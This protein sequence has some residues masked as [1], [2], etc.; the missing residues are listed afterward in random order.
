MKKLVTLLL[1]LALLATI[2]PTLAEGDAWV[3]PSCGTEN[4]ADNRFCGHCGTEKNDSWVC[5]S[6]GTNNSDNFCTHC[7]QPKA[8]GAGVSSASDPIQ[9]PAPQS[10]GDIPDLV[11]HVGVQLKVSNILPG[12]FDRNEKKYNSWEYQ[13]WGDDLSADWIQAYIEA[14][15]AVSDFRYVDHYL[16]GN[17]ATGFYSDIYYFCYTGSRQVVGSLSLDMWSDGCRLAHNLV[18]VVT[19]YETGNS[20]HIAISLHAVDGLSYAGDYVQVNEFY[21]NGKRIGN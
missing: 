11:A 17:P 7:G 21:E 4:P 10:Q 8:G 16:K 18:L 12:Q 13:Y 2:L 14:V 9:Q 5:P 15:P 1:C 19:H 6:C 3:C 20:K